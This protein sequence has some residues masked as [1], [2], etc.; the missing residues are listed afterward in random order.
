MNKKAY[1]EKL[2]TILSYNHETGIF[3]WKIPKPGGIKV[4]D[5]AGTLRTD[6]YIQIEADRKLYYA[7]RLAWFFKYGY[8]PENNIDHID[9]IKHHNWISNLR[10]VSNQCNAR[11]C[12][13]FI[14]NTSGV[15]GVSWDKN[16]G[17]WF[18]H[19]AINNKPKNLG[20][21]FSFS[22]A[23]CARLA[24]E[25]CL[26]WEGCDSNSPAYQYVQKNILSD[27]QYS[28]NM[29]ASPLIFRRFK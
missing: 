26:D 19:V 9:R 25:Q 5:I 18:A 23:V 22:N 8:S 24:A 20:E 11:N 4:G 15:K 14:N 10:E 1:S 21:Y 7:H 17:K 16:R 27:K 28:E 12:G 2:K 13:N 3:I 29:T 6:G